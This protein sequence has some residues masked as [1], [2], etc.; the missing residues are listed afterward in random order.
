MDRLTPTPD[1]D[2]WI[3]LRVYRSEEQLLVDWCYLG[4][5]K[6][7]E[8][9]FDQTIGICLEHPF[10]LLFRHQTRIDLL[11][12]RHERQPGLKPTGFIFHMSRSGS[13]LVSRMLAALAENIVISEARPID[14][15]LRAGFSSPPVSVEQAIEWMRVMVSALG[16][17]R[18][19]KEKHFFIKFEAW[20]V[21]SL[22][23]IRQAFPEVPWIFVYRDPISVLVSQMEQVGQ[24]IPAGLHQSIFGADAGAVVSLPPEEYYAVVLATFCHGALS[25]LHNGGLLINYEELPQAISTIS[26]FFGVDWSQAELETMNQTTRTHSKY[27]SKPFRDDSG[28]KQDKATEQIRQAAQKWLYPLYDKLET[29]RG[30]REPVGRS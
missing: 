11:K 4:R 23:L 9:F 14:S 16:Q 12:S 19:E 28:L 30:S 5:K 20:H 27:P 18:Q 8:P 10:N 29:A 6:F 17:S 2:G 1:L 24:M 22:P 15:I 21:L 26:G 3:P 13:T 25:Q 7:T